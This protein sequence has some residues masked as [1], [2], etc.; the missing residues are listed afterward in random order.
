MGSDSIPHINTRKQQSERLPCNSTKPSEASVSIVSTTENIFCFPLDSLKKRATTYQRV[1]RSQPLLGTFFRFIRTKVHDPSH[2]E[3]PPS[4]KSL[5]RPR[6]AGLAET[7]RA[8][9]AGPYSCGQILTIATS[10]P[11]FG[12]QPP[13]QRHYT[14]PR[15]H[16]PSNA[17]S[18]TSRCHP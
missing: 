10:F 14:P 13:C 7:R 11:K 17:Q 2:Q 8:K 12:R 9:P 6:Q 1:P 18:H 3:P 5:R 16:D 15:S 4:L